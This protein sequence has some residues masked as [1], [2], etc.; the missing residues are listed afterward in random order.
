LKPDLKV[1]F[2]DDIDFK[3]LLLQ[4]KRVFLFDF[5][6]TINAWKSTMIPKNIEQIFNYL[7]SNGAIVYIVSN[8]KPRTLNIKIPVIWRALK[9]FP[10]K[11]Q[12]KIGNYLNDKSQI[13]VIGDQFFTD[14]LFGKFLGAYTIKVEPLDTKKE[15]ITTKFLRLLEKI[16]KF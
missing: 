10:F 5:D 14:I 3:T 13:V 11:V 15:F 9:P 6:N 4:G 8:G 2:I 1:R 7:I 12:R 16:F